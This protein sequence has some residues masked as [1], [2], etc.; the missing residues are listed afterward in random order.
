MVDAGQG[1]TREELAG[2]SEG[3]RSAQSARGEAYQRSQPAMIQETMARLG[4][5]RQAEAQRMATASNVLAQTGQQ[6]AMAAVLGRSARMPGQVAGQF[7]TGAFGLQAAP[8]L[9]NPESQYGAALAGMNQTNIMNARMASAANKA[10]ILGATV[11]AA[12]DFA[13][14]KWGNPG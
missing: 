7:G 2:I 4:M 8:Q 5:G 11:K 14:A 9:Y 12:G 13:G 3:V 1:M 10:A 6:D